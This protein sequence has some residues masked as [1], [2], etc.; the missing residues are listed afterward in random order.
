MGEEAVEDG[1]RHFSFSECKFGV[2]GWDKPTKGTATILLF[3]ASREEPEES[4]WYNKPDIDTCK[5]FC[6]SPPSQRFQLHHQPV[7]KK[8]F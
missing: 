7:F 8:D 1:N 6:K 4:L 5:A 3:A 2:W